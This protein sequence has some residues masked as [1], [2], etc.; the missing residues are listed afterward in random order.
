M[1]SSDTGMRR[2]I[3]LALTM[4]L[5]WT[6]IAPLLAVDAEAN[7]SACCRR[8]GK[9]HCT[10]CMRGH[11]SNQ[12]GVTTVAEKCQCPPPIAV[13]AHFPSFKPGSAATRLAEAVSRPAFAPQTRAYLQLLSKC[14][15]PKRGPPTP[16]A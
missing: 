11:N 15:N 13:T 3:A 14:G 5:G 7:V 4:L 16:L 1:V 12:Q 8:H 2:T 9:H 6:L 10:C